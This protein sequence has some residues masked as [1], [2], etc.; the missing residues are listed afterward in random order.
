LAAK[1]AAKAAK[2]EARAAKASEAGLRKRSSRKKDDS[3]ASTAVVDGLDGDAAAATTALSQPA[4]SRKASSAKS[5]SG[6]ASGDAESVS[7]AMPL[8]GHRFFIVTPLLQSKRADVAESIRALGG[9]L[10]SQCSA[11]TTHLLIGDGAVRS[12]TDKQRA[13]REAALARGVPQ[14]S[15]NDFS[16]LLQRAVATAAEADAAAAQTQPAAQE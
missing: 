16:Q 1:E 10:Q 3:S 12:E 13:A 9:A 4:R 15:E 7:F 11:S 8:S 2:L 6:V 14:L 5:A